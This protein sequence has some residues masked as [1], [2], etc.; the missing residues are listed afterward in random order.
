MQIP[1]NTFFLVIKD[2]SAEFKNNSPKSFK[3]K[4]EIVLEEKGTIIIIKNWSLYIS[5]QEML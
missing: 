3:S 2:I 5:P 1:Q 4:H